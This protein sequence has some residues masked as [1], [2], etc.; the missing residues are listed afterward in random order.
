MPRFLKA[1]EIPMK[2]RR[3]HLNRY[4]SQLRDALLNPTLTLE[5]KDNIRAK[6]ARIGQPKVYEGNPLQTDNNKAAPMETPLSTLV[7]LDRDDLLAT[8]VHEGVEIDESWSKTEIANA[9]LECRS[10]ST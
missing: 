2:H 8:A 5:E 6:I 10:A 4:K 7:A 3:P 1:H 9:I